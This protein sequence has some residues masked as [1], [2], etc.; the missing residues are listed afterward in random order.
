ML[1]AL[2]RLGRKETYLNKVKV[3]YRK[4]SAINNLN[5]EKPKTTKIKQKQKQNKTSYFR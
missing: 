2:K 4:D 5:R 1:K 3:T